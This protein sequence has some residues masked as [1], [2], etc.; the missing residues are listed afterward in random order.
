[1]EKWFSPWVDHPFT[2]F[3]VSH[4][5]MLVIY[6]LILVSFCAGSR[7]ISSNREISSW[8]RWFLFSLLFVSEISYQA[9]AIV[10]GLWNAADYLPLH[11]CGIA[12]LAGMAAL[13]YP[14]PKLVQITFFLAVI[15]AFLALLTPDLPHDYQH[16]RFWKFFLHHMA[17]SW[18]GIFLIIVY[19]VK[20]NWRNAFEVFGYVA[21]YAIIISFINESIGSNYLY[22]ERTP[23]TATP[24][25]YLGE[26]WWYYI[27][28]SALTLGA[29]LL[30]T[31]LYK[32]IK[33]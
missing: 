3:G 8:I 27:N 5:V 16:Y 25:D 29:F 6:A 9:W 1:M 22:L 21:L 28:L 19:E 32:L 23:A 30:L 7:W 33:R 20:I 4:I 18:T 10:N 17:I 24:L 15:P 2:M 12:S 11:L 14:A 13:A 26:G 31:L